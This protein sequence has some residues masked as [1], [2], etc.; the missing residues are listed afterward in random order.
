MLITHPHLLG[1]EFA[2]RYGN[3]AP[4]SPSTGFQELI[5]ESDAGDSQATGD[6]AIANTAADHT[7]D[8]LAAQMGTPA[9]VGRLVAPQQEFAPLPG[10]DMGDYMLDA[11][12]FDDDDLG[13]DAIDID[14]IIKFDD[15]EDSDDATS[16]IYMPPKNDP[17][18][19]IASQIP[20][21]ANA[22]ITAFRNNAD[23]NFTTFSTSHFSELSELSTPVRRTSRKRKAVDS[24]YS[25]AHYA[26][27]TPVQRMRDPNPPSAPATPNTS[28]RPKRQRLMTA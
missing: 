14:N 1:E 4:A 27:V 3:S 28:N 9:N 7:I 2:R 5:E 23:P 26:G 22:N 24:P 11:D 13:E 16:P 17:S 6:V 10:F 21:F 18:F 20:S 15:S 19:P 25:S 12:D 8:P